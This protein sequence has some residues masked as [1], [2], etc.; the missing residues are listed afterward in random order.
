MNDLETQL[1][2]A[3]LRA[4][5]EE[6]RREREFKRKNGVYFYRPHWKQHKFHTN[7]ATG[8]YMR[9]GN[10][11]GKS[12]CG[13][14]ED[15]SLCLGQRPF[16]R[17]PFDVKDGTGAV[18]YSHPGG[19]DHP[20]VRCGIPDRP[21][22]GLI[23]VVDWDMSEKIFFNRTGD[24]D[25]LGK[26]FKFCPAEAIG[27]I[28]TD[29]KGRVIQIEI[30]RETWVGGGSSTLTIDTVYSYKTNKLGAESADWDFIHVDEPCPESMFNA[31]ARGLMD[32]EGTRYWFNCTP[33]TEMWIN[34]RFT[35]PKQRMGF[36]A[37]EGLAF[38]KEPG[39]TRYLITG[40]IHDNPNVSELSK[41]E[42]FS[43]LNRDERACR[44]F[45]LPTAMAGMVY[46]EFD[47]DTHVLA[48]VPAGWEDYN[49]PPANYTIRWWFDYHTRLPQAVL[50]FAT[51]PK[52]RIFVYDELFDDNLIKPVAESIIDRTAGYFVA[53][54]EIDPF[55]LIDH[56]VTGENVADELAKFDLFVD[57]A[58]KDLR[59]GINKVREKLAERDPNGNPTIYFSPR[60]TQTLFEFNHYIYDPVKNEPIDDHNHMMENLYRAILNGLT[61]IAPPS[62]SEYSNR[63]KTVIRG[64]EDLRNPFRVKAAHLR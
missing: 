49:R 8:R 20:F 44:E 58:T 43:S 3:E 64:D 34:D 24:Y 2:I 39:L 52:G 56:P 18:R 6:L 23:I 62:A 51:D 27:K 45:G 40:S 37:P 28:K 38:E 5:N 7:T 36:E 12:E 26:F 16:Y 22:K 55:A 63:R 13:I 30:K 42:F 29:Q 17:V 10:R 54:C 33:L 59:T 50:F 19:D 11:G 53:N 46:K 32:R 48:E 47:Y 15:I 4:Q 61:Y 35:P 60:L 57:P 14:V 9:F 25:T 41:R 21:V 31:H 1:K